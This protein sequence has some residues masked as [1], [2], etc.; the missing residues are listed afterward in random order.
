MYY[1]IV[2]KKDKAKSKVVLNINVRIK[3]FQIE[4]YHVLV[5]ESKLSLSFNLSNSLTTY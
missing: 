1:L 5:S 4:S 3:F 2:Y